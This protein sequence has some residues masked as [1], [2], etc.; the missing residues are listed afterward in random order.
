MHYILNKK[1]ILL[2]ILLILTPALAVAD[3]LNGAD[4]SWILTS[5]ALVLFMTIPVIN[6]YFDY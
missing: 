2:S 1:N 6:S 5:T 3:E 4:T